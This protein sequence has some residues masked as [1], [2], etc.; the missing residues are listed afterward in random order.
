MEEIAKFFL[1]GKNGQL[2]V[3]EDKVVIT[4]KGFYG[5]LCQGVAGGKTIPY[6]TIKT[7]QLQLGSNW[8]NGFIQFGILGGRER[9]GG[10][11]NAIED[12]NSIVF[13]K[14]ENKVA[15]YIKEYIEEKIAAVT[16]PRF[17]QQISPADEVLKL[18]HLLDMGVLT[19]EE[20]DLKKKQ[21]LGL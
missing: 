16:P 19:Q 13:V 8:V 11:S 17:V 3:Y 1:N 7:I 6:R 14:R 10:I 5:F 4:R 12:E 18:K 20:F 15:E 2:Y 9:H 21:L